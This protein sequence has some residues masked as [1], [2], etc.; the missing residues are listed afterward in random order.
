MPLAHR[1]Y[2]DGT[3][4]TNGQFDEVNY[5]TIKFTNTNIGASVIDEVTFSGDVQRNLFPNGF[6]DGF[7]S[8]AGCSFAYSA[9]PLDPAGNSRTTFLQST[10]GVISSKQISNTNLGTYAGLNANSINGFSLFA[11][12]NGVQY[13]ELIVDDSGGNGY[14]AN[15][16]IL[17]GLVTQTFINGNA[18]IV[19]TKITNY[20]DGWFRCFV[21][22]TVGA[23]PTRASIV[24][25]STST[26]S[27]YPLSTIPS[28]NGIYMYGPQVN[29]YAWP[30]P[31]FDKANS[32]S[33]IANN[34]SFRID[35]NSNLY[36]IN[37]T[38]DEV[39]VIS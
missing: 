33:Y 1:L 30:T 39:T 22:G 11:K 12:S 7:W 15:F 37:G 18:T 26:A 23:N 24:L 14:V 10:S 19:S 29:V 36:V 4:A 5:N 31:Y 20:G 38:M 28:G 21:S 9:T 6:R 16:D 35:K 3:L 8:A 32:V 13:F 17:N 25:M 34:N 2:K 27:W